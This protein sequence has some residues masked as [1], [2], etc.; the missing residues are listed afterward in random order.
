M[1]HWTETLFKDQAGM[2][3]RL[4][5]RR[6]DE[7]GEDAQHLLRLVEDQKGKRPDSVLDV[8][9]GT[10]RHVLAFA[11]EGCYA[12]GL[13]FSEDFIDQARDRAVRKGLEDSVDFHVHDMRELDEFDGSFDLITRFWNSLGYCDKTT[14]TEL[15][16]KMKGLLSDD[17]SVAIEMGNKEHQIKNYESSSVREVDGYL[18]VSRTDFDIKCSRFQTTVDVFSIEDTGYE[19]VETMEF[20]PRL[21]APVE[22]KEM[23]ENAGF[24]EVSVFGGFE[25]ETLSL[26][27]PRVVVLAS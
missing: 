13:D 10:G 21:Y 5:D 22:L 1:T 20:K 23:C 24:K 27:S 6:F 8:A 19:Y 25:G 18:H 14:D 7:A 12:E 11:E 15:L 2:F 16:S 4:F 26:D 9:C 17:G 3:A